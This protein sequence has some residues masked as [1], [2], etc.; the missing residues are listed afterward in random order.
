MFEVE[1]DDV[2]LMPYLTLHF[3]QQ[4]LGS[5]PPRIKLEP[6]SSVRYLQKDAYGSESFWAAAG[7][8]IVAEASNTPRWPPLNTR[9][10]IAVYNATFRDRRRIHLPRIWRTCKV[11]KLRRWILCKK[12]TRCWPDRQNLLCSSPPACRACSWRFEWF[13]WWKYGFLRWWHG[14]SQWRRRGWR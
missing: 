6:L 1:G 9:G 13:V 14:L 7:G 5:C 11:T 3:W 2:F 4:I 12:L 8:T 10:C